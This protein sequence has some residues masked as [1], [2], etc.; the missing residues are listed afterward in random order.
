MVEAITNRHPHSMRLVIFVVLICVGCQAVLVP[1]DGGPRDAGRPQLN[2]TDAG[3]PTDGG[4][5]PVDGGND[6]VDGGNDPVDGGNDLVDGGNDPVDGGNDPPDAGV[7]E[8]P[9]VDFDFSSTG[10]RHIVSGGVDLLGGN[11]SYY[12]I[13]SCSGADDPGQNVVSIGATGGTLFAPGNCPGPPFAIDVT[14]TSNNSVHVSVIIG[15]T[16]VEYRGFS[17]PL[18]ARK[19]Y[20]ST[21]NTSSDGFGV[22][23]GG[24]YEPRGGGGG[25]F[26]DIPTPCFIPAAGPVGTARFAP[27]P[28]WGEISGSFGTI[29]RTVTSGDARELYFYNHPNTNNIEVSF[30]TDGN[31]PAGSTLRLEEDIVVTA[32]AVL[33]TRSEVLL[34][35]VY[36]AVLGR[37]PDPSGVVSFGPTIEASGADG[38]TEVATAMLQ[39]AEFANLRAALSSGQLVDQLYRGLLSRAADPAGLANFTPVVDEGRVLDV[40]NG[41]LASA[42]FTTAYPLAAP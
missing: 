13:G 12:I 29:R 10:I 28:A 19:N 42:E 41:L 11:G 4:N 18:D 26:A 24:G 37:E 3:D 34:P 32:P 5:D 1:P 36:R 14:R 23:C 6:P 7:A 15:P 27:V 2:G 8:G 30:T 39:S 25:N 38:M 21:F 17:V 20:F 9:F 40:F 31:L 16:A 35:L 22:G 33:A